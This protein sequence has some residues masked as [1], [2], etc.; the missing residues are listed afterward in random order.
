MVTFKERYQGP[1]DVPQPI[2][3]FPL[4]RTILLPRAML[5]LNVFEPRYLA[6]LEDVMA[7]PRVLLIVQPAGGEGESPPGKSVELRRVG[8]A[9]RVTSYQELDDGRLS[10]ALT[11]I[12]RCSIAA[13]VE[14]GKPYRSCTV[15]FE[16]YLADFLPGSED[17][18]DRTSLI[19]TLK[20]YLEA[21]QMRADWSAISKASDEW[22]V[23]SLAVV[24]PYGPEEKQALLE[25]PDLKARAEAL[26]ALAEMELASSGGGSG[27]TLQ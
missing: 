18:V 15:G 12:A 26:V 5:P 3:V 13:E 27:S 11:G 9:G 20:A 14:T 6:M 19:A 21:R 7:G 2:P 16:R 22:L 24:A 1:A 10:I 8:C 4:L 17:D 25:A 23:N